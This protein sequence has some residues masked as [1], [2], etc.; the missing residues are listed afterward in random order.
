VT[1]RSSFGDPYRAWEGPKTPTSSRVTSS[2]LQIIDQQMRQGRL[3]LFPADDS[4]QKRIAL[5][6]TGK[7]RP[8]AAPLRLN[9]NCMPHRTL[10]EIN[11][12]VA[13][14]DFKS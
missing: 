11:L 7:S 12:A 3:R 2:F 13:A 5:V 9:Q 6:A 1:K 8:P 10:L 14:P 4:L